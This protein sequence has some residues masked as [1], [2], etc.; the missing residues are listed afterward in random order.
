M[1]ASLKTHVLLRRTPNPTPDD[2]PAFSCPGA[3]PA[4]KEQ[5]NPF[6]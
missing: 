3:D 4:E 2:G 6:L 5:K 1:E